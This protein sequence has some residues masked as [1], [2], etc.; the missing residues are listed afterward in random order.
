ETVNMTQ[1]VRG[2]DSNGVLL[3]TVEVTGDV[4][5][6]PPGSVITLQP[7]NENYIQTGGGSLFATSI[8]TF[9]VGEY[10]LPYAWNQTISYDAQLGRMPYLV[11]TL[12]ADG[13][14]SFYSNSQAELNLIVSTNISPGSPRDSCP[15]GFTLDK[16]G[17]YCRD[18]DECVTSTS[19]C[20]H[21]CTNTVGSYSCTC[22]PG[23]TLGPDG[24]TCQDVDECSM[25]NVCGPQQQCDNT[26][27]SYTCTYTCRHGLRRT[28]S[29]TACEG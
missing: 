14:G 10:H 26:P 21:G 15:S 28:S 2:V 1:V 11:E 12:R 19:R 3:V 24:Y 7:Y 4:P 5:Y 6:L 29:G 27:G 20:S 22:T 18:N 23:Y 13:L 25:V 16:S 8:R 9:S 17:P